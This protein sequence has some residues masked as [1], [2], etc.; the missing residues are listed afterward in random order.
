AY[1][2]G[3]LLVRSAADA[4]SLAIAVQKEMQA[5]ATNMPYVNVQYFNQIVAPELQAWRLGAAMVSSF[6]II[7]VLIAMVGLCGVSAY[8]VTPRTHEIGIR[9]ALGAHR[10]EV[11]RMVLG[12]GMRV[13]LIGVAL[14]TVAALVA[15]RYLGDLLYETSPSDPRVLIGVAV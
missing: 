5:L 14:G 11:L 13:V 15:G 12:Q 1:G 8:L 9:M 4:P 2:P 3:A 10:G 7:A 6:G